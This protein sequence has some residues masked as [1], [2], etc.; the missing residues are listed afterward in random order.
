MDFKKLSAQARRLVDRRGGS[1]ALKQDFNELKD[2]AKS[3]GSVADKAKQA[4]AA[5]KDPGAK[6]ADPATGAPA[7]AADPAVHPAPEPEPSAPDAGLQPDPE[8]PAS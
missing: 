1:D 7:A 2:I 8:G 6:H 4:A 5:L 3:E